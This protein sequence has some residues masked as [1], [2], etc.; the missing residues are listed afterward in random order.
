M[1]RTVAVASTGGRGRAA[2]QDVGTCGQ[3]L[4]EHAERDETGAQGVTLWRRRHDDATPDSAAVWKRP[5][6]ESAAESPAENRPHVTCP[7]FPPDLARTVKLCPPPTKTA[8]QSSQDWMRG[9]RTPAR[10]GR[11]LTKVCSDPAVVAALL[12]VCACDVLHF[13]NEFCNS[14]SHL[15]LP[16]DN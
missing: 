13:Y 10:L 14:E 5:C 1:A 11:P 6:R 3:V 2:A 4:K 15:G 12:S 16:V 8:Q 9:R 7:V